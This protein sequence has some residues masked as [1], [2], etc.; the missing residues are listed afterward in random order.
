MAS[1]MFLDDGD[2][3]F[4]RVA[5][6]APL[7]ERNEE[8][9][10]IRAWQ[11]DGDAAALDRLI[12]SHAR[13]VLKITR[14]FRGYGL[15]HGD[16]VQEGNAGLMEAA[17]RFETDRDVRF[18]TYAS[19]WIAAGMQSYVLRN[20]SIVR[21]GTTPA[22]RRLFFNLRRLRAQLTQQ[23]NEVMSDAD[24]RAIADKLHVPVAAVERMEVHFSARDRSLNAPM[25]DADS[26]QHQDQLADP[27]PPPEQI[28]IAH[29]D[30]A[31]R[32]EWL[33]AAIDRL[34]SREQQIIRRRFFTD[35]KLTLAE[36]GETFGV[37]KERIRQI[38]AK[39][40]SKLR[41]YLLEVTSDRSDFFSH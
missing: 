35:R 31:T 26:D 34:T 30:D 29:H 40:I 27:G 38:E 37:S 11:A 39:A 18:S 32:A 2:K 14:R 41:G 7:L 20:W 5:M 28:A 9:G 16:L 10:L 3:R 4:I 1:A 25:G 13:L 21:T 17:V 6:K 24:R 15:P 22:Q 33:R 23:T 12:I 19:W 8:R 36:I